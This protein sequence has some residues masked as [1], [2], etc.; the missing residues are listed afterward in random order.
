MNAR[1]LIAAAVL[2][3]AATATAAAQ[4]QV[5]ST[6]QDPSYRPGW[7]FTPSFGYSQ[8]YDDNISLFAVRTVEDLNN[9]FVSSYTPAADLHYSGKHTVVGAGYSGS[10]LAFRTFNLLNRWDQSGRFYARRQESERLK[11]SAVADAAAVPT[12]DSIDLGGIPYRRMGATVANARSGA[13]Y[14]LD[15]RNDLVGSVGYQSIRFDRAE[16]PGGFLQGGHAIDALGGWRHHLSAR[17]GLGADYGLRRA[18]AIGESEAFTIHSFQ[19]AADYQV[20][21]SWS[22]SGSA[23]VVVLQPNALTQSRTGPAWRFSAERHRARTTLT[24]WYLRSYIPSFAFGGTVKTQELGFGMH[25]PLFHSRYFY[26][27]HSA[28]FRDDQPLTDL[29]NQ[30]PLRSLRTNSVFGWAPQPWVRIE[31]FYARVQQSTLRY[32]GQAYRNRIG[33]QIV[34]SKPMRIE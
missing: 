27:E 7:T 2:A 31:A 21:P 8:I 24:A 12:T 33:V 3:A 11:W 29:L 18:V 20:S 1:E 25:A 22:L 16:L 13:E 10:F 4:G 23:G 30:L 32:G 17:V 15:S 28:R 6:G 14:R 19:G 5:A 34:T 9:D 26:T